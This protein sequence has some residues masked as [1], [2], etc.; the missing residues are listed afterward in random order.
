ML[1]HATGALPDDFPPLT[2]EVN[3]ADR[4]QDGVTVFNVMP[5]SPVPEG[6]PP[7]DAGW[8][9]ALDGDG[10]VVWYHRMTHQLLDVDVTP[11]GTF[12]VS[13]SELNVVEV[14]LLGRTV[15]DWAG[16]I[17]GDGRGTDLQGRPLVTEESQPID[18][19]S[20]HHEVTEL[21]NGNT[22]T[23]STELLEIAADDAAA[24]LCPDDPGTN[25]IGDVVVELDPLP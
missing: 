21:P 23:L 8:I 9:V 11:R 12:I 22:L 25:L 2:L 7:P 24:R 6:V 5:F 20:A 13:A 16:R 15:K 18:I 4:R 19:D 17:A 10:E 14:D 3:D 1:D